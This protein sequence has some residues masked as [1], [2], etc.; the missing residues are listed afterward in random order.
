M[1]ETSI[2]L[3]DLIRRILL[4]W[5]A[6]VIWMIIFA[7][8]IDGI[9][10]IRALR[11]TSGTEE[12]TAA[13]ETQDAFA[14]YEQGLSE[15]E[16]MEVQVAVQA[17]TEMYQ[18]YLETLEYCENSIRMQLD[19]NSVSTATLLYYIEASA[20]DSETGVSTNEIIDVLNATAQS[21]DVCSQILDGLNWDTETA[22]IQELIMISADEDIDVNAEEYSGERDL[23]ITVMAPDEESAVIMAEIIRTAVEKEASGLQE[24][25]GEF[26]M[27]LIQDQYAQKADRDLLAD[28]QNKYSGLNTLRTALN[29]LANSMS[30]EQK[31]YYYALL[32]GTVTNQAV[33]DKGET[34]TEISTAVV[35]PAQPKLISGRYVVIGLLVGLVLVIICVMIGYVCKGKLR[36]KE[37][38]EE[39]YHIPLLGFF[40]ATER[41]RLKG[42]VCR[43]INR[44]F[45]R[46]DAKYSVE[47]RTRMICAS[48]RLAAEK[49]GMES[50]YLTG[51]GENPQSEQLMAQI[52]E[53]LKESIQS[54]SYGRSIIY[55]PESLERMTTADGVVLVECVDVSAYAD[56]ERETELCSTYDAPI[57]GGIVIR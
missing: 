35:S 36:V 41:T 25:I 21:E 27:E 2:D 24:T 42:P 51:T 49:A 50:I 52:A 37:D 19:A 15:R 14:E 30:D 54:V 33:E 32:D 45:Y 17:Y 10:Y 44:F 48:I 8:L 40:E 5:K 9:Y 34:E 39:L 29:N 12:T 22:Y 6:I 38:I 57:I 13:K 7:F 16:I 1:K 18:N 47:E 28:Q 56:M 3:I 31:E 4:R 11:A 55:D 53:Q 20:S 26:D 46:R 43:G 23:T